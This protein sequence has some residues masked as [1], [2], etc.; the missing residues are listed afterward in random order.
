MASHLE[1]FITLDHS[2]HQETFRSSGAQGMA[3]P[4]GIIEVILVPSLLGQV[5]PKVLTVAL[6]L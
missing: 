5:V 4:V 6:T 1:E 2:C 3:P